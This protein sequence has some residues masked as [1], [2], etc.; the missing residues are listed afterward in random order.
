MRRSIVRSIS[1][2]LAIAILFT[3][4]ATAAPMYEENA[5]PELE[6]YDEG[7]VVRSTYN[8]LSPE[9]RAIFDRIIAS[10]PELSEFH[11]ENVDPF[12]NRYD[13]QQYAVNSYAVDLAS[14]LANKLAALSLV[15]DVSYCLNAMG[16]DMAAAANGGS[17]VLGGILIA[18]ATAEA[19]VT[20]AANWDTVSEKFNRIVDSFTSVFADAA[21][22]VVS[23][24]DE[25]KGEV[26]AARTGIN[27]SVVVNGR[28]AYVGSRTFSCAVA[29]DALR[30]QDVRNKKYFA[31]VIY[32]DDVYVDINHP[33]NDTDARMILSLNRSDIGVVAVSEKYARG[34]AG[35]CP[36]GPE[37]H[38]WSGYYKHYHNTLF[39]K[40][41][42]WYPHVDFSAYGEEVD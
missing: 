17:L 1:L 15:P 3:I 39:P 28:T 13:I 31:G 4:S 11:K 36:K 21:S 30:E 10:D 32:S 25:I 22:A 5:K 29:V 18:A 40:A 24:F 42:I 37:E 14:Q 27:I 16:S 23:A 7:E 6:A 9:A 38:G 2:F 8:N 33:L 20:I 12:F 41:H 19:V 35:S 34:L 26:P